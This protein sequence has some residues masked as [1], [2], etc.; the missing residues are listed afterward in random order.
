VDPLLPDDSK[1]AD[2]Y[3]LLA[4]CY[5]P[6]NESLGEALHGFVRQSPGLADELLHSF[7][8]AGGIEA[9]SVDYGAL[10]LGPFK[11][12]APPYGSVY[13]EDATVM[14]DSTMN[15]KSLYSQEGLDV[16]IKEPPDHICV[17]LEFL[18]FLIRREADENA[19]GDP[20]AAAVY[21]RKQQSFLELHLGAWV[22]EFAER[23][24]QQA[25]TDFYRTLARL[26]H[27]F[28]IDDAQR[29]RQ[30]L[31]GQEFDN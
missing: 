2:S 22:A 25:R 18:A 3:S 10:F 11:L 7:E 6:P 15:A 24:E 21:R 28:V 17:E 29:L 12:L 8:D 20:E 9:L 27:D 23:V 4:R 1:R 26:T 5:H 13:M 16:S 19:M 31:G 14:G 30:K